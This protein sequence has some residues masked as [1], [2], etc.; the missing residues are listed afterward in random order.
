MHA[1]NIWSH[2]GRSAASGRDRV[3]QRLI[4]CKWSKI[5]SV[6]QSPPT[7]HETG[8]ASTTSS[9]A[10]TQD[11][12]RQS[13]HLFE[14]KISDCSLKELDGGERGKRAGEVDGEARTRKIHGSVGAWTSKNHGSEGTRIRNNNWSLGTRLGKKYSHGLGTGQEIF[15][16]NNQVS[17]MQLEQ[18][19][20][21]SIKIKMKAE[22]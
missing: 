19:H 15:T 22:T 11:Q 6:R 5:R 3:P 21:D 16:R 12:I 9:R 7:E 4:G 14:H 13:F 8:L 1:V 2:N 10:R 17:R 18:T 20:F